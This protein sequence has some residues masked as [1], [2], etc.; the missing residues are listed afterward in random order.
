MINDQ[1]D[2]QNVRL[3]VDGRYDQ[4]ALDY[5]R[6]ECGFLLQAGAHSTGKVLGPAGAHPTLAATRRFAAG[7]HGSGLARGRDRSVA[8]SADFHQLLEPC[9]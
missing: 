4:I 9:D 6:L 7:Q 1:S 2:P 8:G 5:T 3:I